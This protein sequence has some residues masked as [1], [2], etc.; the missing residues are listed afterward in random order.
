MSKEL[1]EKRKILDSLLESKSKI[2]EQ[3]QENIKILDTHPSIDN[4][5]LLCQQGKVSETDFLSYKDIREAIEVQVNGFPQVMQVLGTEIEQIR[6]EIKDLEQQ[7][8]KERRK[9][10]GG[11]ER[12]QIAVGKAVLCV[13]GTVVGYISFSISYEILNYIIDLIA[14]VP[15]L[16]VILYWPSDISMAKI[17]L[18]TT[19]SVMVGAWVCVKICGG[20]KLFSSLIVL[21]YIASM[22]IWFVSYG[23]SLRILFTFAMFI[24]SACITFNLKRSDT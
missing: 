17:V 12:I 20:A 24:I 10:L 18:P 13:L 7:E 23:F 9:N 2:Q 4:A 16:R 8:K 22:I 19:S 1:D 15:F 21:L 6:T 3:Q 5:Y 14:Q 11:E